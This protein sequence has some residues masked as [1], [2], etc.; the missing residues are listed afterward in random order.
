MLQ[1]RF[2]NW[3]PAPFL[4]GSRWSVSIYP[5]VGARADAT[6]SDWIFVLES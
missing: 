6:S 5:A 1:N 3:H 2:A 4:E